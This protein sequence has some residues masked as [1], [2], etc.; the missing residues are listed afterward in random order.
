MTDVKPGMS[1]FENLSS[2]PNLVHANEIQWMQYFYN[3]LA[4]PKPAINS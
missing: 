4:V 2:V 3:L 1:F